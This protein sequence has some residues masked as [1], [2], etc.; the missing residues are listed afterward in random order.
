MNQA[1]TQSFIEDSIHY[2][3]LN[4]PRIANCLNRLS[5]EQIWQ[6]PNP[7]CN[8]IANLV[9]HLCG[10]ITQYMLS[11]LGG[12]ED[13]RQRDLEFSTKAGYDKAMLIAKIT[14]VN[15]RAA[16][17][18]R[19][20]DTTSLLKKRMVQGFDMTGL[21]IIVHVTEHFSYHVGQIALLTKLMVGEDLGFYA[22]LDLNIK[23]EE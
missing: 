12:A 9:L 20:Q 7:S 19:Q 11:S 13:I 21:A 22:D 1:L 18:M 10:N 5:E 6:Q 4:V 23:N 3:E 8:S 14:E 16:E 2:M 17:A 15:N